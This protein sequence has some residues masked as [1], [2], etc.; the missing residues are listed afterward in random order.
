YSVVTG[1]STQKG[2]LRADILLNQQP[3]AQTTHIDITIATFRLYLSPQTRSKSAAAVAAQPMQS[4]NSVLNVKVE[5]VMDTALVA[6]ILAASGFR[7]ALALR[8]R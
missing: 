6:C 7:F 4:S 3:P 8:D 1:F 5:P 2:A